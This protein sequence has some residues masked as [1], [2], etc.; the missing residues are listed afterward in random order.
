LLDV[1]VREAKG[2]VEE[3]TLR[4]NAGKAIGYVPANLCGVFRNL[5][6]HALIKE[7]KCIS[8]QDPTISRRPPVGQSFKKKK[9][10]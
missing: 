6:D 8:L 3:Q 9:Q 1:V 2:K 7:I 10:R 4:T 5:L